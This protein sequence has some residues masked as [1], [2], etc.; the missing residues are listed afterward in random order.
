M[1]TWTISAASIF[2]LKIRQNVFIKRI[3]MKTF[4]SQYYLQKT[5]GR[6]DRNTA[7]QH[8]Y[9]ELVQVNDHL[10]ANGITRTIVSDYA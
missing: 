9:R 8:I 5:L 4:N 2:Q 10:R 3:I 7:A 6:A 1:F